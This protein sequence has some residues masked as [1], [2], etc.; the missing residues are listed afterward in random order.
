M[1]SSPYQVKADVINELRNVLYYNRHEIE[2][3]VTNQ[4]GKSHKKVVNKVI[5]LL[6][7]NN[8]A[9]Q[10]IDLLVKYIPDQQP[11]PQ[12]Q[13]IP[14]EPVPSEDDGIKKID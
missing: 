8:A 14:V 1:A 5:R 10:A 9:E 13:Q 11:Q 3:L 12:G 6:N 7:E 2:R 4:S